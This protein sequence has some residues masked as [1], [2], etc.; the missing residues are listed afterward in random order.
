[1]KLLMIL[2]LASFYRTELT[3]KIWY[4]SESYNL[5]PDF[6]YH[7][8]QWVFYDPDNTLPPDNI[9]TFNSNHELYLIRTENAVNVFNIVPRFEDT[10]RLKYRFYLPNKDFSITP[11]HKVKSPHYVVWDIDKNCNTFSNKPIVSAKFRYFD[12]E[13]NAHVFWEKLTSTDKLRHN[14]LVFDKFDRLL[15]PVNNKFTSV[16]EIIEHFSVSKSCPI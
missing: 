11:N 16:D 15:Q 1:M 12:C 10:P 7:N 13:E 14:G 5:Y 4:I 2:F 3:Q 6:T 8:I 9:G